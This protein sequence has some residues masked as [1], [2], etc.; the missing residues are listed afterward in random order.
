[1]TA[2]RASAPEYFNL[3]HGGC[4]STTM[5]LEDFKTPRYVLGVLLTWLQ[6]AD[7]LE[8]ADMLDRSNIV[9]PNLKS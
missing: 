2:I 3:H 1:M 9:K 5:T 6:V 4:H 8:V 7:M